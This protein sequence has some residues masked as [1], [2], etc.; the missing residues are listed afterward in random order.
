[1]AARAEANLGRQPATELGR[2]VQRVLDGRAGGGGDGRQRRG[3]LEAR[4]VR[5][6]RRGHAAFGAGRR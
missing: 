4:G 3:R 5:R 2:A 6:G 1:M